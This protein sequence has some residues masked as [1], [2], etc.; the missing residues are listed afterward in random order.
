M[1]EKINKLVEKVHVGYRYV[2]LDKVIIESDKTRDTL[3]I[4][5]IS[6]QIEIAL[7]PHTITMLY[8][9]FRYLKTDLDEG[10]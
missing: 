5:D 8:E 10:L 3:I 1:T 7:T 6:K 4:D 9:F 2:T